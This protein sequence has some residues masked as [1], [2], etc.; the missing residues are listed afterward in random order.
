MVPIKVMNPTTETI[1]LHKNRQLEEFNLFDNT[2]DMFPI[3][4]SMCTHAEIKEDKDQMG[5]RNNNNRRS[6]EDKCL[7]YSDME[8]NYLLS[9]QQSQLNELLV[10]NKE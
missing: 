3:V 4:K 2:I 7:P 1:T 9:S 10:K 8:V 5:Q 6:S